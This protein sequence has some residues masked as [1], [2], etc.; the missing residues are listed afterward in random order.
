[1][2]RHHSI[3]KTEKFNDD[4]ND[5]S[6]QRDNQSDEL[7]RSPCIGHNDSFKKTESN[8]FL[9]D[10]NL[11][12]TTGQ[13]EEFND[14]Y[15]TNRTFEV[16][17][18][19]SEESENVST[20]DHSIL[21]KRDNQNDSV[22]ENF[23]QN[24]NLDSSEELKN[25]QP[26]EHQIL[27]TTYDLVNEKQ[28]DINFYRLPIIDPIESEQVELDDSESHTILNR[29]YDL[30]ENEPLLDNSGSHKHSILNRTYDLGLASNSKNTNLV[31]VSSVIEPSI[32]QNSLLD[33]NYDENSKIG[34]KK[35]LSSKFF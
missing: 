27:N 16:M 29:T 25:Y 17:N 19:Q 35:M 5:S 9:Q 23:L 24:F 4:H 2:S 26:D 20:H 6:N 10:F 15:I 22:I 31:T 18:D 32:I 21:N 12:S 14:H 13:L 28:D 3:H 8:H 11:S 1:M 7:E 30:V 33:G 34:Q